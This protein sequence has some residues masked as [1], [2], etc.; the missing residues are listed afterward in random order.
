MLRLR[1]D[2]IHNMLQQLV[3]LAGTVNW[4][5]LETVC[6]APYSDDPKIK[7]DQPPL[8]T[9]LTAGLQI[10][11]FTLDLSDEELCDRWVENPYF[12]FFCGEATPR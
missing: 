12:Q 3:R 11:K 2:Q 8:P 6:G 1:I 9:R 4:G 7:G 5:Q 10:L